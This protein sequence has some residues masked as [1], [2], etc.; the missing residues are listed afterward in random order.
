MTAKQLVCV[1]CRNWKSEKCDYCLEA[2]K[3]SEGNIALGGFPDDVLFTHYKH[4]HLTPE[5]WEQ[6]TGEKLP[7]NTP[8]W[9][10]IMMKW[11]IKIY[12]E[13]KWARGSEYLL[14]C[15]GSEVP[16]DYREGR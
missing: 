3:N 5:E 12:A 15:N 9:V 4:T 13:C 6:R 7:D 14:V 11:E 16:S 2:G 1:N 8:V 10:Y